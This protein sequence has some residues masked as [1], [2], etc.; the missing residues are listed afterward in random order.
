MGRSAEQLCHW[1]AWLDVTSVK[2]HRWR[3]GVQPSPRAQA[4]LG[5][6]G[7]RCHPVSSWGQAE[8]TFQSLKGQSS[9][10]RFYWVFNTLRP[11]QNKL[12]I[13]EHPFAPST[14]KAW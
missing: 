1:D 13:P 10:A 5:S 8:A 4:S 6:R 2:Q 3:S 9:L 14:V 11:L 7:R 12:N